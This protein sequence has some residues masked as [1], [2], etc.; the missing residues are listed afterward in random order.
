MK[1]ICVLLLLGGAALAKPKD[2]TVKL[3]KGTVVLPGDWFACATD[4]DCTIAMGPREC[5]KTMVPINKKFR[6]DAEK[7]MSPMCAGEELGGVVG[8][9]GPSCKANEC[10]R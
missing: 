8:G 4:Q 9:V 1:T 5:W 3:E 7:K 6:K 10:E 2:R